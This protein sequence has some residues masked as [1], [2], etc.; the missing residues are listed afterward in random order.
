MSQS[1]HEPLRKN[2]D[3][4]SGGGSSNHQNTPSRFIDEGFHNAVREA[5]QHQVSMHSTQ[6]Q[7]QQQ[8]D[9]GDI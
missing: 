3:E 5:Q 7:R 6:S 8:E 9:H 1:P 4:T 2:A